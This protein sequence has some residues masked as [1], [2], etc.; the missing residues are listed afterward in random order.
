MRTRIAANPFA[1]PTSL[2]L[3]LNTYGIGDFV[4]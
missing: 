1:Y 3:Q 4:L 2:V